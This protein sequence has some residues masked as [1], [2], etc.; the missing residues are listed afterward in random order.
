[1]T[2]NRRQTSDAR[3]QS[4]DQIA[5]YGIEVFARHGVL[6]AEKEHGQRFVI[7]VDLFLDLSKAAVSDRLADTIDYGKLAQ[8]IH[9]VV[10]SERWDLLERVAGR[11]AEVGLNDPRV[12]HIKVTVHKPEAPI[13]VSF[14]DIAV[15]LTRSR[16]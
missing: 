10:A 16:A 1:M 13:A 2:E 5:I 11:V 7:D 15:T 12:D 8:R 3:R 9:D 6:S 14:G 4:D